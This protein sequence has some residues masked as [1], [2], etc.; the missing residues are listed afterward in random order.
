MP[1]VS[2]RPETVISADPEAPD[3]PEALRAAFDV[4]HLAMAD[5]EIYKALL[6]EWSSRF[7]LIG[8]SVLPNFWRRHVLD[9]A[10][11]ATLAPT[12]LSWT[13]LGSGAGFPGLVLAILLKHRSGA[14]V[15]LVESVAK[16]CRFLEQVIAD[17]SLPAAVHQ[18]RAESLSLP[19]EVVTARACAPLPRLLGFAAPH[20]RSGAI[21]LFLK[22]RDVE[23]E[24]TEARRQW[25]FRVEQLPSLSDAGGR[26]LKVEGLQRA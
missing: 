23:S 11:L 21:G 13:D 19:A 8:P 12:A 15:N 1:D 26:I 24:L 5:L 2:P 9:S 3:S 7:N 17:L 14:R 4:S 18:A 22:G 25:R 6:T 20:L 16:R 10:Q